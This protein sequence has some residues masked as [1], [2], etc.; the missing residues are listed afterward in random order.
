MAHYQNPRT[1]HIVGTLGHGPLSKPLDSA[2]SRDPR[3]RH[4]VGTL[5]QLHTPGTLS[6]D[7]ALSNQDPQE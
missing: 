6:Q 5:D 3:P 2:Y 7:R 4:T 1:S